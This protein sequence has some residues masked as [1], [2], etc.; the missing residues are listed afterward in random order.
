[1]REILLQLI[2]L[3]ILDEKQKETPN[4]PKTLKNEEIRFEHSNKNSHY[5]SAKKPTKRPTE[6]LTHT[7]SSVEW[8]SVLHI[9]SLDIFTILIVT[10][11]LQHESAYVRLNLLL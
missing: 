4:K 2:M 3:R 6:S 11:Q 10:A 8:Q 9:W 5:S 7:D 1:M